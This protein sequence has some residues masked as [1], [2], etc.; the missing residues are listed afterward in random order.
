VSLRPESLSSELSLPPDMTT[1]RSAAQYAGW[2]VANRLIASARHGTIAWPQ[3]APV[4]RMK[5]HR[6]GRHASRSSA[7]Q[8]VSPVPRLRIKG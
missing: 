3:C 4:S 6:H 1:M 2:N 7:S 5:E 8:A